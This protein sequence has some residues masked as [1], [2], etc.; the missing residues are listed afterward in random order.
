[1]YK[2]IELKLKLRKALAI[3]KQNV[4]NLHKL[5]IEN[6]VADNSEETAEMIAKKYV[7]FENK[8]D[9]YQ[10]MINEGMLEIKNL[11]AEISK[12]ENIKIDIQNYSEEEMINFL[13][14]MPESKKEKDTYGDG[15][16]DDDFENWIEEENKRAKKIKDLEKEV[17]KLEKEDKEL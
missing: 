12:W 14:S 3:Y 2:L 15:L 7:E 8:F 9:L 17:K 13:N 5:C 4:K 6:Y 10:S 16:Y 1:M 11:T